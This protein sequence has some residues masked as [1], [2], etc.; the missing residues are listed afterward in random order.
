MTPLIQNFRYRPEIDGLHAIAVLAVVV[1][2]T[3]LGVK[4]QISPNADHWV[5]AY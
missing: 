4:A 3:G 2:H 5:A 1:F